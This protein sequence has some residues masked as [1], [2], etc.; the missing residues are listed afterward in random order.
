MLSLPGELVSARNSGEQRPTGPTN[1]S[2]DPA[3]VTRLGLAS[4]LPLLRVWGGSHCS[5]SARWGLHRGVGSTELR[6]WG[7]GYRRTASDKPTEHRDGGRGSRKDARCEQGVTEEMGSH[8]R[9]P[10]QLSLPIPT[11]QWRKM[12]DALGLPWGHPVVPR[13]VT[14]PRWEDALHRADGSACEGQPKL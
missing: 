14:C 8:G 3:P 7:S 11:V 9:M 10:V 6:T 13:Q 2:I 1:P 4:T 5:H 12:C